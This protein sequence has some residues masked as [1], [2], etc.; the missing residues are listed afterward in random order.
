MKTVVITG[1]N[2]GIGFAAAKYI[3]GHSGWQVV[4]ACRNPAKAEAALE[5]IRRVH[6]Q[7]SVSTLLLDLLS[8]QSIR[9]FAASLEKQELPPLQGLVL[10]AGGI[11]MR[12]KS[13]E[14]SEDS[15]EHIFQLNFLGHF[16][17]TNLLVGKMQAPARIVFVSSDLHDPAA[18]RMGKIAPPKYGRAESDG[19]LRYGQ[20]VCNDVRSRTGSQTEGTG[21]KGHHGEFLVPRRCADDGVQRRCAAASKENHEVR[22]VVGAIR[23][24]HGITSFNGR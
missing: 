12:A 13:L 10:N 3:A 1:A 2:A 15:F 5:E 6:P 17:L 16:A 24:V 23:E 21:N 4:L 20:N 11:N 22:S 18:T 19:A 7:A 8:L 9:D 14:F